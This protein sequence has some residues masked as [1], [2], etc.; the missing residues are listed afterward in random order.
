MG[1]NLFM[2]AWLP[3]LLAVL[4]LSVAMMGQFLPEPFR[5]R[6]RAPRTKLIISGVVILLIGVKIGWLNGS[7]PDPV[8]LWIGGMVAG[9]A[10][11]QIIAAIKVRWLLGR[12]WES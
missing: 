1:G 8:S 4:A 7:R 11:A 5:A 10:L 2:G 12:A 3:I 6:I 9:F